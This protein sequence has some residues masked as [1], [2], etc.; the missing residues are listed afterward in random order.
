MGR[1]VAAVELDNVGEGRIELDTHADTCV[2]GKNFLLLEY[3]GRVC[4][5][6]PYSDE[7]QAVKDVPIVSGATAVQDNETGEVYILVVNEG[8]WYGNRLNHSLLNPNQIRYFGLKVQDNPFDATPLH[9]LDPASNVSVALSTQGTT[10]YANS[11]VPTQQE[12]SQCQHIVL[13]SPNPWNP[14]TVHL[15]SVKLKS[16]DHL[17][18]DSY[19]LQQTVYQMAESDGMI[20]SDVSMLSCISSVYSERTFA[21]SVQRHVI[22]AKVDVPNLKTFVSHKRHTDVSVEDLSERWNIGIKQAKDTINATTQ[23]YS[24]SALLPLSRRYRSDRLF[25]RRHLNH[26]FAADLY[27]GRTVSLRGNTCSYLFAHKCGFVQAYPQSKKSESADSLRQFTMD[28]GIPRKL[29]IDGALEQVGAHTAFMKRVR[30]YDIDLHVSGPRLP[31]ENPAE[32]VIR[33]VRKKWFRLMHSKNIPKRLWDYGIQWV[34]EIQQRTT[35]SSMYSQGRTPIEIITG[36]TPDISEYLDFGLYDWVL[37]KENAGLGETKLG[38]M[39]GVSHRVGNMM[40]YWVLTQSSHVV[41]RTTVQRLTNL[42]RSQDIWIHKCKDFDTA[43]LERL[44]DANHVIALNEDDQP[45]DWEAQDF[46][47]D[48]DFSAEFGRALSDDTILE[49]D[50]IAQHSSEPTPD[51]FDTY[52]NMEVS[53]PRGEDN[54]M[55]FAKVT[56]RM[57]DNDGNPIGVAN[58]NPILD[59]RLYEVEWHDGRREALAA[60]VIAEN[61][62]AQVDDEGNRHV[63][64]QDIVDHRKSD[65]AVSGDDAFFTSQSGL[66]QRR[67]T[68]KGWDLCVQWKD[69]STNWIALKDLKNAYPVQ[70]AEY[71]VGNKIHEEAAFAWWV[72]FTLKK[73]E[74]IL[75]KVKS[76]YWLRTH[77]YGVEIP[78]SVGHAKVLDE[79]NGN[80]LWWDA[81]LKEMKNV[82]IAFEKFVGEKKDLPPAFQEIKCH[83]IFDVKLG[84]NF[85][86]KARYVAGG[87]MTEPPA[88]ITYS[89]VVSRESVRIMLMIAALNDLTVM[90]ADIQNAYLHA[91]CREKIWVRAGPE[92]G[93]D[94]G[95]IMIVVRALYGLKSS[96]AAFRSML[97]TRLHEIGYKPTKADPDVWLR[98]A[99]KSDGFEYYEYVL[100]Y[101]DDIFTISHDPAT[102]MDQIQEEFKFKNNEVASPDF[103][104]GAKLERKVINGVDCWTMAS[105]KYVNAAIENVETKLKQD[106]KQ[107]PK[108]CTTPMS[109]KY[110]P[111]EDTTDELQGTDI[112]YYQEL[113]GVL[114]WAIELG[115]IDIMLEVSMLSTHLALPRV[116]HMQQVLHIFGYLKQY[117]RKTLAFDPRHPNIDESKFPAMAD[118][119]DFYRDAEE[120]IPDDAPVPRGRSVSI[121][122]FVDADHASNR[123]TRRSQ[124]G[125]LMFINRAPIIWYSK[126]QNTVESSTFGSEF[127]AM[128]TAVE[129][130]Q[131]LRQK[132]RWFGISI[133]GPANVYG[134]NESVINSAQKPEITLSKKHNGIAYHKCRE[135]VASGMIRVAY[136]NTLSNLADLLTKPLPQPRREVLI[137][138]FMY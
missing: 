62:F 117:P 36:E 34:C 138:C 18:V 2:L 88:S 105:D 124:T 51:S 11:R 114:R 21:Q 85:R 9:I 86:R 80:T 31:K 49:E 107:L 91:P 132:L 104:L 67:R 126:R 32:G 47:A 83:M 43:I 71:A 129:L 90:T 20:N 38:R 125:I 25:Y 136:E 112:T 66:K 15:S 57:R 92:F 103:Y 70:L 123:V 59:T 48:D 74:R 77:K 28:W 45:F 72:P 44:R 61:L 127:V 26:H 40:S 33:E 118:W 12:L 55:E 29:I 16:N 81:I 39:L 75:S 41:S 76:K 82:R 53:L 30:L 22:I 3:S 101:V 116:G 97:A 133:E 100:V 106:F 50:D 46:S 93:S 131:G 13:T 69:G 119:H 102:T 7:Y 52:V 108:K 73:R 63:L 111:E 17:E 65:D 99:C 10:L 24:R 122:C 58:D 19:D 84:E 68:T 60:N 95:A 137:D 14:S 87:H 4:D 98:P 6:Y 78:K 109:S 89:S 115:R 135:A 120:P 1:H 5:V 56:K 54:T 96:G 8:L 121:H 42:E 37:F 110:R 27:M 134:D 130:I 23:R 35:S 128:R 113:V 64:L 79:K 94:Q